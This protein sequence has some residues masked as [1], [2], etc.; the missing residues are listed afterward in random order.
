MSETMV[1]LSMVPRL[2]RNLHSG[3]WSV[4]L[5]KRIWSFSVY[6]PIKFS[7]YWVFSSLSAAPVFSNFSAVRSSLAVLVLDRQP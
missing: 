4:I 7:K 5:P 1:G 2:L 3:N 6:T